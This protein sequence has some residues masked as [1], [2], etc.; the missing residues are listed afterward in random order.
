MLNHV[1]VV[2]LLVLHQTYA[3]SFCIALEFNIPTFSNY[4][5]AISLYCHCEQSHVIKLVTLFS[6][7]EAIFE[8]TRLQN[9]CKNF[10]SN[11]HSN[12]NTLFNHWKWNR[13]IKALYLYVHL[14][15]FQAWWH[16][17]SLIKHKLSS[18]IFMPQPYSFSVHASVC[19]FLK[20]ILIKQFKC[21]FL[22]I[23]TNFLTFCILLI[24]IF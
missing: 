2:K 9:L 24:A 13:F 14:C 3:I 23:W 11:M 20:E 17:I 15:C 16:K 8:R 19:L 5:I 6:V 21:T 7:D 12:S 18:V 1:E 22:I 4:K 10:E